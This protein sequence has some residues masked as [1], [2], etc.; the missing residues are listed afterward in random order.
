MREL[1]LRSKLAMIN[2]Y[3]LLLQLYLKIDPTPQEE[4]CSNNILTSGQISSIPG[5]EPKLMLLLVK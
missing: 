3:P 2:S 4:S 5:Y 1:D